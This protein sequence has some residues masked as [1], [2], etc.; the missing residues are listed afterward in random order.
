MRNCLFPNCIMDKSYFQCNLSKGESCNWRCEDQSPKEI[1]DNSAL[2]PLPLHWI[3]HLCSLLYPFCPSMHWTHLEKIWDSV[4]VPESAQVP[5]RKTHRK[6]PEHQGVQPVRYLS[7]KYIS[8]CIFHVFN[9][10]HFSLIC[11]NSRVPAIH[12]HLD[13]LKAL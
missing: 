7:V 13:R 12:L 5:A 2:P 10:P 4:N 6:V 3:K 9:N 1:G 11:I 8:Q